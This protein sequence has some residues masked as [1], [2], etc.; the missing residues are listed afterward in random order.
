M[1][2]ELSFFTDIIKESITEYNVSLSQNL[3]DVLPQFAG[4]HS[5]FIFM[6][7]KLHDFPF[8]IFG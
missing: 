1:T 2:E 4:N 7:R 8:S 6:K 3:K 5:L